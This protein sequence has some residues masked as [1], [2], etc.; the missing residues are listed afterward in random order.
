M[1]KI[2]LSL[3]VAAT[4]LSLLA[5]EETVGGVLFEVDNVTKTAVVKANNYSGHLY[6][7]DVINEDVEV[8]GVSDDAFTNCADLVSIRFSRN[9]FTL[10]GGIFTGCTGLKTVII[11]AA[12]GTEN[13]I[14]FVGSAGS[15]P[16]DELA[17]EQLYALCLS[18]EVKFVDKVSQ[19]EVTDYSSSYNTL[20]LKMLA[21]GNRVSK[22]GENAFKNSKIK[23]ILCQAQE[24]PVC[25]STAFE[26]SR[27]KGEDWRNWC[28]LT[29]PNG[30]LSVYQTADVWKDIP[31]KN[32]PYQAQATYAEP[33]VISG[34]SSMLIPSGLNDPNNLYV[35]MN[36]GR[37]IAGGTYL[38][39]EYPVDTLLYP[40][41]EAGAD[42][43]D[44][45]NKYQGMMMKIPAGTGYLE[46][47]AL[48]AGYHYMSVAIEGQDIQLFRVT[49]RDTIKVPFDVKRESKVYIFSSMPG[50]ESVGMPPFRMPAA[51]GGQTNIYGIG[52]HVDKPILAIDAVASEQNSGVKIIRDGQLYIMY[53]GTM[54]NVQGAKVK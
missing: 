13:V 21:I 54:Y 31:N 17:P 22:I 51:S 45:E 23:S 25:A 1:R 27:I 44:L 19:A 14:T 5:S 41:L 20:G 49:E 33:Q 32:Q 37:Y 48:N 34:D 53:K 38:S 2:F 50:G 28:V 10:N 8:V 30:A 16:F 4:S 29:V 18:K 3:L 35:T 12:E 40:L 52:W 47:D 36:G 42:S 6:I 43:K 15:F 9:I 46:I 39:Y 24:P 26:Q 7:P 11:P